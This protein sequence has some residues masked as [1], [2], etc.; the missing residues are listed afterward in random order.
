[1]IETGQ[2]Y[3]KDEYPGWRVS[4]YYDEDASAPQADWDM[5]AGAH[6]YRDTIRT[7]G[8]TGLPGSTSVFRDVYGHDGMDAEELSEYIP[9]DGVV[10]GLRYHAGYDICPHES[11]DPTDWDGYF[12]VRQKHWESIMG[13][14][15]MT[16]EAVREALADDCKVIRAWI[17]GQVYGWVL[18]KETV[19]TN[20]DGRTRTTW[21]DEDSCWGYYG[22]D[23]WDRMA[24]EGFGRIPNEEDE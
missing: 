12:Y 9:D 21:E 5:I 11:D 14:K 24:D 3:E 2:V 4:I 10:I 18:E 23:E 1:M 19:W 8:P 13:D 15:P 6:D 16:P 20:E 22:L 7:W 17:E